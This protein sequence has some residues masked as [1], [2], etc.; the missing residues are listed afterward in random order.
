MDIQD[1]LENE[2]FLIVFGSPMKTVCNKLTLRSGVLIISALD[3]M[4]SVFYFILIATCFATGF[5]GLGFIPLVIIQL[6]FIINNFVSGFF[7][8]VG[9][10]A[11][12]NLNPSLMHTYSRYKIVELFTLGVLKMFIFVIYTAFFIGIQNPAFHVVSFLCFSTIIASGMLAKIVW[13]AEKRMANN[14]LELFRNGEQRNT[15]ESQMSEFNKN[16]V[17]VPGMSLGSVCPPQN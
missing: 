14:Q 7:G 8:C 3:I 15:G 4:I 1:A 12:L 10:R 6:I 17:Y 13:S 2:K 5:F 11:C 16:R 9:L